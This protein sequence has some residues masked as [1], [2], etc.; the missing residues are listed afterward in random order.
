MRKR[1]LFGLLLAALLCTT[2]V[3]GA[4][5]LAGRYLYGLAV[6]AGGITLQN[7]E[8]ISNGT[9][10]TITLTGIAGISGGISDCGILYN[11]VI[12]DTAGEDITLA[13]YNVVVGWGAG[14]EMTEGLNNVFIGKSAGGK[15]TG[16]PGGTGLSSYNT[17]IGVDSG[18]ALTSGKEN[19][20]Y[21]NDSGYPITIGNYNT[22]IGDYAGYGATAT[23]NNNVC[24]GYEAGYS[25]TGDSKLYI[26]SGRSANLITGDFAM[27]VVNIG[28]SPNNG[29]LGVG[30]AEG[31]LPSGIIEAS[32]EGGAKTDYTLLALDNTKSAADMDGTGTQIAFYQKP[33]GTTSLVQSA[34]IV[35]A[36]ETDWTTTASTQD[37]RFS[38]YVVENGGLVEAVRFKSDKTVQLFGCA[39]GT[40]VTDA[41]GNVSAPGVETKTD[42][43]IVTTSDAGKTLV[44]NAATAKTFSLPSVSAGNV[45]MPPITF[46]KIGAGQVTID[47]ADSDTIADSGAGDTIYDGQANET[48]ATITL[49]LVSD[50]KWAVV[51]G[52]GTWTT[53][54]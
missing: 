20:F 15:S 7:G 6:G 24:L 47:A 54:D 42:D 17:C 38:L 13:N 52:H 33:H 9:D 22:M 23:I 2:P 4:M 12:G 45:N 32:G 51:G 35:S 44:M 25:S 19:T 53:S 30:L 11:V 14:K 27:G 26:S 40:L 36:T 37:G 48:Y 21:G 28:I 46:V 50:T 41:S 39:S 29:L 10:G 5:R 34:G 49:K 3:Q 18:Q 16:A 1:L 43:Y 8:T 31:A